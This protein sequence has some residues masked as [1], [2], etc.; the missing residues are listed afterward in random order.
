M[1]S[2]SM[3][4]VEFERRILR[5][6]DIAGADI[7]L[8][9]LRRLFRES[10][11][12]APRYGNAAR[13]FYQP[14]EPFLVDDVVERRHPGRIARVALDPI[15]NW[16]RRDL[17]PD[18]AQA[19]TEA[20]SQA[21]LAGDQTQIDR[22]TRE[23]QDRV[24][25]V[26]GQIFAGTDDKEKRR[27]LAQ[28]GTPQAEEDALNLRR[29]LELRDLLATLSDHLPGY[30]ANLA[31][32]RLSATKELIAAAAVRAPEIV[33][34]ALLV[35]MRRLAS[36]WQLIRL[37]PKTAA[38]ALASEDSYG[39][40][41]PIVMA[42]LGFLTTQLQEDLRNGAVGTIALL[43]VIH[44]AAR[45]LR[46][47]LDPAPDSRWGRELAALRSRVAQSLE[48]E[49]QSVPDRVRRLLRPRPS[50]EISAHS[51][52]DESEVAETEAMIGVVDACRQFAGELALNEM[53][54]RSFS[55]L[56]QFLDHSNG[57]LLDALRHAGDADRSFR[58]SQAD[59]AVRFCRK[60]FG[61]SYAAMLTKAAAV[62][63]HSERKESQPTGA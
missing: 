11:E 58:Q 47:E 46:V 57:A 18:E 40:A 55:D 28:I 52:L 63:G 53:T 12:T 8:E 23:F 43:R 50:A 14:V 7:V 51:T 16:I 4:I 21:L 1:N 27:S 60:T 41:I 2:R 3:L 38:N 49:I 6:D 34:Y 42:E 24:A 37:A 26:L 17:L 44:D 48:P 36:P 45:G 13:I 59:A 15:W 20:A 61:D 31:D 19:F 62:A 56:Q 39:A 9:E 5:G 32:E 25:S 29:I 35:V 10:R 30:I 33:P 22:V 54:Q